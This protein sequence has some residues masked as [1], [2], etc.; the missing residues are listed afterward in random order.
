MQYWKSRIVKLFPNIDLEQIENP[1]KMWGE[2]Y[3]QCKDSIRCG[4]DE[5]FRK[6]FPEM[7]FYLNCKQQLGYAE[8]DYYTS[9]VISFARKLLDL[10]GIDR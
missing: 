10:K 2:L 8:Y 4:D 9:V 7:I 6:V 1:M 5:Y 3:Y